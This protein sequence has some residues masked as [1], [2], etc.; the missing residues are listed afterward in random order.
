MGR[1][2]VNRDGDH[3]GQVR[4]GCHEAEW[5]AEHGGELTEE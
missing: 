3:N 4:E 2:A 1:P 5:I